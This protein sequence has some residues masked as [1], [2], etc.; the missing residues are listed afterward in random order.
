[1]DNLGEPVPKCQNHSGFSAARDDEDE[2]GSNDDKLVD[3]LALNGT[4]STDNRQWRE[5]QGM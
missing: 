2:D 4:F 5:H 1:M 3:W